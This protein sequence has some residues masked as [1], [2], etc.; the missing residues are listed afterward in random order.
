M[1]IPKMEKLDEKDQKIL[2][3]L[4]ENSSLSTQKIAKKTNI[5]ITTVHNRIRKLREIG[6]I[7]GYT[8]IL[9][10]KKLGKN[11]F[12][13]ILVDVDN[14]VLKSG[15][16]SQEELSKKIKNIDI[17]EEISVIGGVSDIILRVG[18][19][20]IEQLND[21]IMNK[22]RAFDAVESTRTMIVLKDV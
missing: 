11:I 9:D 2:N 1:L 15:K 10:Q 19:K 4:I 21:F 17:V 20:D 14:K 13:Y 5:P 6:V 22:L 8:V 12:A 16:M 3:V 7:K 18:V